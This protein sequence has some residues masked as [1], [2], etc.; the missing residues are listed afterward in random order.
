VKNA[1]RFF[2]SLGLAMAAL[3]MLNHPIGT[4][5]A[6]EEAK[7]KSRVSQGTN[8]EVTVLF[9]A[10]TQQRIGLTL[11][12]LAAA[13]LPP[14]VK[15]YGRVLDP[16]PL[17]QLVADL[18][19][20]EVT[21]EAS[22]R[23]LERL[24]LL[25]AQDN[26]SARAVEAAEAQALRDQLL[27]A[28]LRAK[29][30]L[31]WGKAVA[32]SEKLVALAKDLASAQ[33]A[34]VRVDLPAGQPLP[35]KPTGAQLSGLAADAKPIASE[36]LGPATSTDPQFQGQGFLFLVRSNAPTSGAALSARIQMDAA[37]LKGLLIP[38]NAIVRHANKGW[39]Y[40]QTAED[41]FT[42]REVALERGESEG[43]FVTNGFVAGDKVVTTGAQLLLS[44]EL[45]ARGGEE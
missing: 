39:A 36:F 15:A 22:R 24:K 21:A 28:S 8:G 2:G 18:A 14:V 35:G 37:P 16:A 41:K 45:K 40:V 4:A 5:Q 27:A 34:I 10:E 11:A 26:A 13:E 3:G 17:I 43:Y 42:R 9:E 33:T 1:I 44:E 23:E 38:S 7:E 32:E 20:A 19:P 25:R 12:T 30:L 6:A 31:N 29:L